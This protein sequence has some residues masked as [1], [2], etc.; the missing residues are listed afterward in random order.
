MDRNDLKKLPGYKRILS[1]GGRD[2]SG[3]QM[4]KTGAFKFEKGGDYGTY[5]ITKDG[6]VKRQSVQAFKIGW[7]DMSTE[8]S[9]DKAFNG[10]ADKMIQI[11]EKEAR[12]A[13][14]NSEREEDR[15]QAIQNLI[16]HK[17]V[18]SSKKSRNIIK[19][20]FNEPSKY[21]KLLDSGELRYIARSFIRNEETFE[22]LKDVPGAFELI[23]FM[24]LK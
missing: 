13:Q 21:R 7:C 8:A 6:L 22:I 14:L 12:E 19:N 24:D 2:T 11:K 10:I 18:L 17:E 23:Y 15:K 20:F 5:N 9:Y 16:N 1:L 3:P 4:L